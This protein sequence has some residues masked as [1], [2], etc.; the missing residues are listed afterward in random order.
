MKKIILLSIVALSFFTLAAQT[1][2]TFTGRDYNNHFIQLDRVVITNHT[3]NWSDTIFYPDTTL[4]MGQV[5]VNDFQRSNRFELLQNN[6][7][8][9]ESHTTVV[10]RTE[11]KGNVTLVLTDMNGRTVEKSKGLFLQPGIQQF[12][13]Q[14]ANPGTY[15][16]T[17]S[18]NGKNSSIKMINTG[19]GSE[20]KIE[21]GELVKSQDFASLQ[22]KVH[23]DNPFTMGDE[24]SYTGYAMVNDSDLVSQPIHLNQYESAIFSL[25]F[26]TAIFT[27]LAI[28]TTS[29]ATNVST[30]SATCGGNVISDEGY[31]V[32]NKGLCWSTNPNP[33]ASDDNISVGNGLGEFT[34]EISGLSDNT[35]Y[36]VRAFAVNSA[37]IAYGN[38]V[39]FTTLSADTGQHCPGTPTVTDYDGNTYETVLI[40][41]QCWMRQNLRTTHYSDGTSIPLGSEPSYDVPY[42]YCPGNN[43]NNV[44]TYGYLYN[45]TAVM[46]NASSSDSLP[47]GV[48]GVCPTGWHVPGNSEWTQL[49]DYVSSQSQYLCD[50]NSSNIAKALASTTGWNVS[51]YSC[52]VGFNPG[53]NNA[54]GFSAVPAGSFSD[55]FYGFGNNASYWSTT[56]SNDTNAYKFGLSNCFADVTQSGGPLYAGISVRCLRD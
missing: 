23:T 3:Q 47:S 10:L 1:T 4:A 5:G 19:K 28:V 21:Y 13:I 52:T 18:Q 54:T 14:L 20:N 34:C 37:G 22:P 44:D 7:N 39:S 2:V 11:D 45:W 55:S 12:H 41:Q 29:A 25:Y 16:L 31:T 46:R 27:N 35:T 42:R 48:Q 17:A 53:F 43:V 26:N 32:V 33:V 9:F 40:G 30:Y 36:Y 38:E 6:P 15:L 51:H 49:T 56:K 50:D 24:M 8:P